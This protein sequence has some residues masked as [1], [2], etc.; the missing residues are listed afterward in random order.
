[1]LVP[2]CRQIIFCGKIRRN[3]GGA[4][5]SRPLRPRG[6]IAAQGFLSAYKGRPLGTIGDYG[7][8]SFHE[9]KNISMGEGGAIVFNAD[10]DQ[11]RAE[12]IREKRTDRSRFFRGEIDKYIWEDKGSSY[13]PSDINAAFLYGQLEAVQNIFAKR[14]RIWDLYYASLRGLQEE[15]CVELP[16]IL[17]DCVHNAH[18]FYIKCRDMGERA[19]LIAYLKERGIE[20]VFHY[21]PLHT[22]PAERRYARFHGE[23]RY[24]TA[25][26][27]RLLRLPL[28]F[29]MKEEEAFTV[30]QATEDFYHGQ[31][32]QA[33]A[34][35]RAG[36][37]QP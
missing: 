7:C 4:R 35:T 17:D 16:R 18:M 3:I 14:I 20:A 13:L 37:G 25:E 29:S 28:F 30:V 19:Q 22:A 34:E 11:L 24:T 6:F 12:I 5:K 8:F 26:S 2:Q 32:R 33:C 9:T 36:K 10:K 21:I 31:K 23:E 27:Q 15:E 1:M